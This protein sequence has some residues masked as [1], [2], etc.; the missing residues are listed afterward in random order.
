MSDL[1]PLLNESVEKAAK[2]LLIHF[3]EQYGAE[4]FVPLG[5][6]ENTTPAKVVPGIV[7]AF[8]ESMLAV[9]DN[10]V[11]IYMQD[12]RVGYVF[13]SFMNAF[14]GSLNFIVQGIMKALGLKMMWADFKVSLANR[15]Q[16]NQ[17]G[18]IRRKNNLTLVIQWVF[19]EIVNDLKAQ[20]MNVTITNG[21]E[22]FNSVAEAIEKLEIFA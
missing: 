19:D 17:E 7:P 18:Y 2:K 14:F 4:I 13:D 12:D 1:T 20:G 15:K 5:V 6:N 10:T 3:K 9:Q 21:T 11:A 16:N 8:E 22:N